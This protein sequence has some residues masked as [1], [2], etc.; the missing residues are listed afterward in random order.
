[1]KPMRSFTVTLTDSVRYAINLA[2]T[3]PQD[4]EQKAL[5]VW[6]EDFLRF[7]PINAG[8]IHNVVAIENGAAQ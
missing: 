2:A 3:G 7:T 8:D 4:A 6:N 1:M 5:D